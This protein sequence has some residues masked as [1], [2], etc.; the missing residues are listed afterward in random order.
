KCERGLNL[1]MSVSKHHWGAAQ[2]GCLLFY[3]SD[4]LSILDYG[5]Q[6]CGVASTTRLN[7]LDTIQIA[8]LKVALG[9]LSSN[10]NRISLKEDEK[11]PLH[12]RRKLLA[13]RFI[14]RWKTYGKKESIS[15][16]AN[17]A[18]RILTHE[19]WSSLQIPPLVQAFIE[20]SNQI[21]EITTYS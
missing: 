15:L 17:L 16:L 14:V 5:S 10:P 20:S 4:V 8:T 19:Y 18:S 3:K 21:R 12:L 9:L 11:L 1:L 6:F 13:M 7:S 2:S